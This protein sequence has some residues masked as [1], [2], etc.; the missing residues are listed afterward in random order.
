MG[1]RQVKGSLTIEMA[2]LIPL[3]LFLFVDCVWASFYFHDKNILSGAAYE[4]AVVA[5]TRMREKEPPDEAA[6]KNLFRERIDGRL[7]LFR[8]TFVDVDLEKDE[9]TV[10]V[11]AINLPYRL[12]V[13]KRAAV[14]DPEKKIRTQRKVKDGV[15]KLEEG[16]KKLVEGLKENVIDGAL[17]NDGESDDLSGGLPDEDDTGE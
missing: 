14:T 17:H 5:S 7:H 16:I 6:I 3:I 11:T 1:H 15:S 8:S 4:T 2:Y 9:V 12:S 13:E 10:S